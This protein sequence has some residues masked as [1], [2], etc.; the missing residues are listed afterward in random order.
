ML[1]TVK[2]KEYFTQHNQHQAIYALDPVDLTHGGD[3]SEGSEEHQR[4]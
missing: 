4:K 2:S 1:R 3:E